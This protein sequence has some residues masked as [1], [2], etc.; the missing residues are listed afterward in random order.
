MKPL[1]ILQ[2]ETISE[3]IAVIDEYDNRALCI[4]GATDV[5]IALRNRELPEATELLVDIS[6]IAELQGIREDENLIKIAA[7]T[8]HTEIEQDP[9]LQHYAPC[10][11]A[12]ARSIGSPQIRNRGTMGGNIVTA[13][14]C[15]DTIPPLMVLS[16]EIV[17]VS[18]CGTRI[19]PIEEFFTGPKKTARRNNELV[20]EIRFAKPPPNA[21]GY[22]YKLMRKETV[23]KAR[24]SIAAL[25]EQSLDGT[26]S[27]L[28]LSP[29]SVTPR[30]RRFY[31]V[32]QLLEGRKPDEHL[33]EEAAGKT[34]E[35]M[36][37]ITGRRW[38]TPYKEPVLRT[39]AARALKEILTIEEQPHVQ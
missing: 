27:L 11:C 23:A 31:P 34:A 26:I 3:V 30:P 37:S 12:A 29:G 10:L 35:I 8:T 22:F 39:L 4:A 25:A 21:R 38:S 17:L 2:P 6:R 7:G 15:A 5:M 32:E 14:Q 18:R 24:I 33:I 19:L 16:A 36:V 1:A 28:R 9:L 13:A 20:T